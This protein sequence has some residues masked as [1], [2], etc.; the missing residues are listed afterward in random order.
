MLSRTQIV[1]TY[2]DYINKIKKQLAMFK[3]LRWLNFIVLATHAY[4]LAISFTAFYFILIAM[5]IGTISFNE[6]SIATFK[7]R[8]KIAE[9]LRLMHH[10]EL[11]QEIYNPNYR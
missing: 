9:E 6:H 1:K 8:L 10:Q 4:C 11:L 5:S 2:D 3:W 7:A